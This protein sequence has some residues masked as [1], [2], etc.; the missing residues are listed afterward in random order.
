MKRPFSEFSRSTIEEGDLVMAYLVCLEG[1]VRCN[2]FIN[3]STV[4]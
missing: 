4:S 1:E 3:S 2:S